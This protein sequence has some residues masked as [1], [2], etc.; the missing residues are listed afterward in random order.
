MIMI[1][2]LLILIFIITIQSGCLFSN[3]IIQTLSLQ[4]DTIPTRLAYDGQYYYRSLPVRTT[5]GQT[6]RIERVDKTTGVASIVL[7]SGSFSQVDGIGTAATF[8]KIRALVA[9]SGT[10]Y[11]KLFVGDSCKIR[12]VN[13]T[14]L[15]VTTVAGSGMCADTDG[16]GTAAEFEEVLALTADD[17][18]IYIGTTG[19]IRKMNLTTYEVTT[20]AGSASGDVDGIGSSAQISP[21]SGLTKI[22]QNLYFLDTYIKIKKLSL[23]DNTVTTIAGQNGPTYSDSV[24]G[25]VSTATFQFDIVNDMT[26]DGVNFLFFTEYYKIR[27]MNLTTLEV[28]TVLNSSNRYED[29]DSNDISNA[30][31][32]A[33]SGILFNEHGLFFSNIYGIRVLQ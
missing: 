24:D 3:I 17:S 2:R 30:K 31:A 21:M 14:S 22:G 1:Y 13:L 5:T 18:Y 29:V 28:T 9:V 20:L 10:T 16:I 15:Q 33:P 4:E 7:G 12:E 32:F 6:N 25:P 8:S 11:N 27:K 23:N 19:K 26:S